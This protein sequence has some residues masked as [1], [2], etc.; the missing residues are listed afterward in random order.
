[1]GNWGFLTTRNG[2]TWTSTYNSTGRDPS[3]K[4]R[5]LFLGAKIL[6]VCHWT[7]VLQW[8]FPRK[9]MER[10]YVPPLRVRRGCADNQQA[11]SGNSLITIVTASSSAWCQKSSPQHCRMQENE[12]LVK[13]AAGRA[14]HSWPRQIISC[15]SQQTQQSYQQDSTRGLLASLYLNPSVQ[16]CQLVASKIVNTCTPKPSPL[17]LVYILYKYDLSGIYAFCIQYVP[18]I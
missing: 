3:W 16:H 8:T 17:C 11:K 2:V 9:E 5:S 15:D 4:Y 6:T 13:Q 18:G 7:V 14:K 10:L 1:M 12:R